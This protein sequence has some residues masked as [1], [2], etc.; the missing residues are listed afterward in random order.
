MVSLLIRKKYKG[1]NEVKLRTLIGKETIVMLQNN[2]VQAL[3]AVEEV[4]ANPGMSTKTKLLIVSAVI[5]TGG[6]A[7]LGV[8]VGKKLKAR[9]AAKSEAQPEVAEEQAHE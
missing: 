9:R 8:F 6:L 3:E 5:A 4:A 2:E 7:V 1:Y